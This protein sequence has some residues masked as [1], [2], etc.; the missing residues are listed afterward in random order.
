VN[1][2]V[3]ISLIGCIFMSSAALAEVVIDVPDTVSVL[4]ANGVKPEL[5]G[6]I[7][8]SGKTLHLADGQQQIVFR[9]EPYFAQGKNNIGVESDVILGKF[10][11][12]NQ[13][14][15]LSM[16]KYKNLRDAQKNIHSME[17]S[18]NDESGHPISLV[19]DKLLKEGTQFG[20]NFY[21]EMVI[22]NQ[23]NKVASVPSFVPGN[24][25]KINATLPKP[26]TEASHNAPTVESMLHYWYDLADEQT[27]QNFKQFI[28]K[29]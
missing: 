6:S 5:S 24:A 26:S 3:A 4:I 27:K 20:R 12:S 22:Y 19:K 9:F 29:Q 21:T 2:K 16:P 7:F 8:Q 10:Q 11:A 23:S 17:W 18:I 1:T 14:L 28:N 15:V 13:K 25:F